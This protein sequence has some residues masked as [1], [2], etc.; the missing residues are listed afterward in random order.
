MP[1]EHYVWLPRPSLLTFEEID[2]LAGVLT[3]LGVRKM[4]LTGGEPLLRRDLP[5]LV[6]LL[7]GRLGIEDLALTTNGLLLGQQAEPLRRAG[8][9]RVTVSLD[10]LRPDRMQSFSRS[11]RH[12]DLLAGIE[13]AGAAG[14][15]QLKLNSVII[16]G[17]NDDELVDLLEFARSRQAELRFIEYMDVGGATAWRMEEVVSQQEILERLA[18]RYGPIEPVSGPRGSAAP[19]ER[20]R[21]PD[22]TVFGVIASTTRPFCRTCDRARL[23]ADGQLLFCLYADRGLDLRELLRRGADDAELASSIRS[24]WERRTDRG[25]EERAGIADRGI[26]YPVAALR[27]DPHREMH[28]RGG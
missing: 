16:R 27:V 22:G 15:K 12:A 2:R 25:A 11:D 3:G 6:R 20:F 19:A 4:R 8:L 17:F 23:T 26:L 1:E 9:G 5:T 14:F 21:L 7:A 10:T 18:L 24:A 28:T 13:A